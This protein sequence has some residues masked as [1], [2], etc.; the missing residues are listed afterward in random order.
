[1][2]VIKS[3]VLLAALLA[4]GACGGGGGGGGTGSAG[5]SGTQ[6]SGSDPSNTAT[7]TPPA[8]SPTVANSTAPLGNTGTASGGQVTNTTNNLVD[9]AAYVAM[10]AKMGAADGIAYRYGDDPAAPAIQKGNVAQ[11]YQ[12][13]DHVRTNA[14]DGGYWQV[15]GPETSNLGDYMQNFYNTLFVADAPD[16]RVGVASLV[17]ATTTWN[18][19]MQRPQPIPLMQ[20]RIYTQAQVE[21]DYAGVEFGGLDDFH[22]QDLGARRPV[23]GA[24]CFGNPGWCLE[25]VV[26][27]Q[28]GL[29]STAWG[30]NTGSNQASLKLPANK[31]PTAVTQTNSGEFALI[32]V[33][34]TAAQKGQIAVIALAGICQ[35]CDPLKP[36]SGNYWGEWG[37]TYPG[38]PNRGNI[39]FMKL[40][41]FVDL[42]ETMRAPTEIAATTGWNPWDGR[43]VDSNGNFVDHYATPLTNETIRQTYVSGNNVGAYANGGVAVVVSKSEQ[44]AAFVDLKPLFSYYRS[45]YFGA[46]SNFDQTAALGQ[47]DNQWPFAFSQMPASARPQVVKVL[48]LG[49]RPTAVKAT[50]WGSNLR[51][52]IATQEGNLRLFNLGGYGNGSGANV[53]AIAQV[54]SV[55]VGRNP[56]SIA[57]VRGSGEGNSGNQINENLMVLSRAEG[58]VRWVD[59]S[60][61]RNSGTV[62]PNVLRDSRIVDPIAIED[63]ENHGTT[64]L[65]LTMADYGGKAVRSYRWGA[66]VFNTNPGGA[67]NPPT[68][69]LMGADNQAK[70]EYGG[71]TVLPGK[72]FMVTG[73]NVP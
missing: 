8:T 11:L 5:G 16:T 31:V 62:R 17:T 4:L 32:T 1:M 2:K 61:D 56:T 47:A 43:P 10:A 15:G 9:P 19:F 38:L 12:R 54:G 70:F 23:A 14:S 44:R 25:P 63:N 39:G 46:K 30:S 68:G 7:S 55:A 20:G 50:M 65:M 52:F 35:G 45:M 18:T 72:P 28:N 40:L 71:A 36:S 60:A 6:A 58:A 66:V 27:Y 34:D 21:S 41:G 42:P 24:R 13:A 49:A 73:A 29:V 26:A 59:L 69:C 67:C 57:Y 64:F 53:D 33:W 22:G 3:S 48:D 37:A 51:A